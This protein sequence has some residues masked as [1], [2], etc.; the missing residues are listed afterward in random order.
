MTFGL[1]LS[2]F[3]NVF[4]FPL[5]KGLPPTL[6][7]PV[8]S[9]ALRTHRASSLSPVILRDLCVPCYFPHRKSASLSCLSSPT[10]GPMDSR[11]PCACLAHFPTSSRFTLLSLF[12]FL[13][14]TAIHFLL[15]ICLS[16]Q[17]NCIYYQMLALCMFPCSWAF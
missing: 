17:Q 8:S 6:L 1:L 14:H 15:L 9:Q 7:S 10:V 11:Y 2:L 4:F 12:F 3:Q 5:L 13:T 16:V